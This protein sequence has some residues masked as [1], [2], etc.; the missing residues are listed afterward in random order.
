MRNH[1]FIFLACLVVIC[2]G[3]AFAASPAITNADFSAVPVGCPGFA[4]QAF[5]GDCTSVPQQQDFNG[6]PGFGWILDQGGTGL[7]VANSAFNPPDFTGLPFSEAVFLQGAGS[8]VY[9][10]IGG[11]SAGADY[12]LSF[13]AGSRYFNNPPFSDGNQTV[14]ATIDGIVVGEWAFTSFSPFTQETVPFSVSTGGTH[15]LSLDGIT[16]GD[17][18]AFVSGVSITQPVPEPATLM[19]F[20]S[21]IGM[22]VRRLR[23][24][25]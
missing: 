21:G 19:L 12:V 24:E 7:T 25:R 17:H 20:G 14:Q 13:Y 22:A 4:Y 6:T 1:R 15:I 23:K 8:F 10:A 2:S 18:T 3:A 11:F 5:A 16:P 9:Q